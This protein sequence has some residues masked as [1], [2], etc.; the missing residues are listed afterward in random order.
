[1]KL[2]YIIGLVVLAIGFATIL[3]MNSDA[4]AYVNFK[5]A[6]ALAEDGSDKKVHVVG[7][8][9]KDVAGTMKYSYNP[10]MDPNYFSFKLIDNN[11]QERE[12]VYLNPM[13]Q[14]FE[15]SEQI[16][17]IGSM[18]QGTFLADQILMKCPSKYQDEEFRPVE[19]KPVPANASM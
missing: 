14:D 3:S 16:V 12:V 9:A 17:V 1:M 19:K 10:K 7:K 11:N 4:S 8:V 13:P 5:E 18:K 6:T 15:R 2:K